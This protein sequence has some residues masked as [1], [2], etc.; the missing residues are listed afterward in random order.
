VYPNFWGLFSIANNGVGTEIAS[1]TAG[2]VGEAVAVG[3]TGTAVGDE[4][5]V[6]VDSTV[7]VGPVVDMGVNAGWIGTLVC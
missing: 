3:A 6:A 7:E 5:A 4:S 1:S 2:A